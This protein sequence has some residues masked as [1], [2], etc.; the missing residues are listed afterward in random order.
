MSRYLSEPFVTSD[1]ACA[2][3]TAAI[4]LVH[5]IEGG[6]SLLARNVEMC[7][8][9]GLCLH[10]LRSGSPVVES[11]L[12]NLIRLPQRRFHNT[13][14][15]AEHERVKIRQAAGF[16]SHGLEVWQLSARPL[17]AVLMKV[18]LQAITRLAVGW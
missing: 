9:S 15:V 10:D 11:C 4:V 2:S 16:F 18:P 1:S 12:C 8:Y 7:S 6:V 17:V 5:C 14:V 3:G 13:I